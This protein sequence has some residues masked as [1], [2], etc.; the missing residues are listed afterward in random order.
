MRK[1]FIP[2]FVF[3]LC[4]G[5][6]WQW[7]NGLS[8]FTVF[9]HTLAEA[10]QIPRNFPEI[11]FVNQNGKTFKI[12]NQH[13]YILLNFVYLDCPFVCHKVNNQ[14]EQIYHSIDTNIIPSQLEFVTV[15]FDLM[16]D[17]IEKIAKYRNYFGDDI[18]GWTFALPYQINQDKFNKFLNKLGTWAYKVPETGLINHSIY[19]YLISPDNK[20][21]K[22]F[23]PA[24]E[25][26]SLI[27]QEI[28]K[29]IKVC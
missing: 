11:N 18:V 23:D 29:C 21:I 22:T 10:G 14:L 28:N 16:N 5:I 12:E 9:S 8:A 20:I 13:K 25:D 15:S 19:L 7:T 3:F 1:V 24:R 26:N 4:F 2:I 27:I 6:I 17:N